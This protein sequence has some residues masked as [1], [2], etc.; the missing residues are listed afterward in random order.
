MREYYVLVQMCSNPAGLNQSSE[1]ITRKR[2][3]NQVVEVG[4]A[5]TSVLGDLLLSTRWEAVFGSEAGKTHTGRLVL[6]PGSPADTCLTV[7]D[8]IKFG[9][10]KPAKAMLLG[11]PS[12][13]R[14]T[15]FRDLE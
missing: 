11:V 14:V 1:P 5:D 12:N 7:S 4:S 9:V 6:P 3:C 13:R 10:T 2:L 15:C 8:R